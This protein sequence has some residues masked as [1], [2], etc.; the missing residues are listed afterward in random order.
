MPEF[1]VEDTFQITNRGLVLVPGFARDHNVNVG[2]ELELVRPDGT[3]VRDKI[4]GVE[5]RV[6]VR[7]CRP[8]LLAEHGSKE[9]VPIGT[10]VRVAEASTRTR[11]SAYL[12]R[13]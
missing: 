6:R 13:M 3:V 1:R 5:F 2:M 4:A 11:M 9:Q 12:P 8:I 7:E 10:N